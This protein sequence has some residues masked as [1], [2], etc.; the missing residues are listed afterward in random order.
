MANTSLIPDNWRIFSGE[1][2]LETIVEGENAYY[3]FVGQHV[4]WPTNN[5]PPIND[6]MQDVNIQAYR[7]MIFGKKI[8]LTDVSLVI[9][10]HPYTVGFPYAKYNDADPEIATKPYYIVSNA[11]S[12]SHVWKCLENNNGGNS[13][14]EP[15]ISDV[16]TRNEVFLNDGYRWKYIYSV[17]STTVAKFS[18]SSYFP[19]VSN[20]TAEALAVDGAID[21]I[22]VLDSGKGY[23]NYLMGAFSSGDIKINGNNVLYGLTSNSI[24]S[25]VNGFY[26]GCILY[27][28]TGSGVGQ[29]RT[30]KDYLVNGNGKFAVLDTEF[31]TAPVNSDQFQVYPSIGINGDGQQTSNATARAIINTAGNVVQRV[32]MLARGKN[33]QF[34]TSNV[35]ANAVVGVDAVANVRAIYSPAGGHGANAANEL[36]AT[37]F[38]AA[39]KL[40]NSEG[41]TVP[42]TNQFHQ[43]GILHDP[44]F[45]NVQFTLT[46][47]GTTPFATGEVI[48]KI[49][50]VY[51]GSNAVTNST[52]NTITRSG[53]HFDLQLHTGDYIFLSGASDASHTMLTTVTGVTNSTQIVIATNCLFTDSNTTISLANVKSQGVVKNRTSNTVIHVD[54]V[55]FGWTTG[56]IVVGNTSGAYGTI[57]TITLNDVNKNLSTFVA[58]HKYTGTITTGSFNLNESVFEGPTLATSTANAYLQSAVSNGST[59]VLYVSNQVGVFSSTITGANSGASY[60]ISQS[61]SPDVKFGSGKIIYMENINGVTRSANTN[62]NFNVVFR[63]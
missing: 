44:I 52:A 45:S 2:L 36:R 42:Y 47:T 21:V 37:A 41:N 5:P 46:S 48:A 53:A 25:S 10:N 11:G 19:L 62:E 56:D 27:I 3:L 40:A 12:Y 4:N 23:D 7:N 34:M 63:F 33:Y 9:N 60:S 51:I 61:Y 16:D 6:D 24:A 31:T 20:T 14:T 50:D 49:T 43:Y 39:V 18:S 1:N 28:S 22:E 57:S 8:A 55:N 32:E 30:I 38:C 35:V 15:H 58:M 59:V 29:F 17:D 26:T 13:V 54:N